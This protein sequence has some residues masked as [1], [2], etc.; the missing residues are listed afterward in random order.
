MSACK[1]LSSKSEYFTQTACQAVICWKPDT[2]CV[3]SSSSSSCRGFYGWCNANG[4]L[5]LQSHLQTGPG[6]SLSRPVFCP[7]IFPPLDWYS[8]PSVVSFERIS[9]RE[10]V[11]SG[12]Q[13]LR[14]EEWGLTLTSYMASQSVSQSVS[15][16]SVKLRLPHSADVRLVA[17]TRLH[18]PPLEHGLCLAER[19]VGGENTDHRWVLSHQVTII[20]TWCNNRHLVYC[21]QISYISREIQT[22][23][24]SL[25]ITITIT[26]FSLVFLHFLVVSYCKARLVFMHGLETF[27][28]AMS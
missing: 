4:G 11:A 13:T 23:A 3:C 10:R 9:S 5:V 16:T 18:Q 14:S 20:I 27:K 12:V 25:K 21:S 24:F 8:P 2:G 17:S 15:L 6:P 7:E 1:Y 28:A 26:G 22:G 19:R